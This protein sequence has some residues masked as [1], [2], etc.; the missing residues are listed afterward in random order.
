MIGLIGNLEKIKKSKFSN[1]LKYTEGYDNL[2]YAYVNGNLVGQEPSD[3][4][5]HDQ[6]N[7]EDDN[8][9]KNVGTCQFCD[10]TVYKSEVIEEDYGYCN[11]CDAIIDDTHIIK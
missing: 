3:W 10:N 6:Y 5:L 7:Y 9:L 11:G 2:G 8:L 1:R 4:D